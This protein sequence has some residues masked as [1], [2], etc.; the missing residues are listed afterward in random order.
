[1]NKTSKERGKSKVKGQKILRL[2]GC[3][4]RG[5]VFFKAT[6]AGMETRMN[7]EV[8]RHYDNKRGRQDAEHT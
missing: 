7:M 4:L 3:G 2:Q 5:A 1:M 6:E 8:G